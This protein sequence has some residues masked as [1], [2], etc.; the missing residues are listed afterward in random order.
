MPAGQVQTGGRHASPVLLL[1][2]LNQAVIIII[3]VKKTCCL[4]SVYSPI[5]QLKSSSLTATKSLGKAALA[6]FRVGRQQHLGPTGTGRSGSPWCSWGWPSDHY[7]LQ[8]CKPSWLP[9]YEGTCRPRST[10]TGMPSG[11]RHFFPSNW[12]PLAYRTTPRAGGTS[13]NVSLIQLSR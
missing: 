13:R 3:I 12:S 4:V 11:M 1:E 5:W 9:S 7:S 6:T 10:R 2:N 8:L